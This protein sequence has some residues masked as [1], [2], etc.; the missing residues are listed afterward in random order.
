MRNAL[1][2]L[3]FLLCG[4]CARFENPIEAESG[5]ALDPALI[6]R[7]FAEGPDGRFEM[8]IVR[9]GNEGRI[10]ATSTEK[11]EAPILEELRLITAR[12][13]RQTFASVT[14][15]GSGAG[16]NWTLLRYEL[17]TPDRLVIFLDDGRA[18][19]DAVRNKQIPG[20]ADEA[21]RV[22]NS[23]VTASSEELRVFILGYGSVIFGDQ[24]NGEFKR[25]P[26]N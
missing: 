12:L 25:L 6:G 18:W 20:V 4:A 11:G 24:P 21:G 16:G 2:A 9:N 13:E 17:A 7:W 3:L 5:A 1:L 14:G 23:R 22:R 26:A 8:E 19:D 10:V 15:S